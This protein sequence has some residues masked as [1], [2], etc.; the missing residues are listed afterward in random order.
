MFFFSFRRYKNAY[1]W[2]LSCLPHFYNSQIVWERTH[3]GRQPSAQSSTTKETRSVPSKSLFG[4]DTRT[5]SYFMQTAEMRVAQ[6]TRIL[7]SP[8]PVF[9]SFSFLSSFCCPLLCKHRP[10][11]KMF[12]VML[13]FASQQLEPLTGVL[14]GY[15]CQWLQKK[16][17][18]PSSQS[19]KL[20]HEVMEGKKLSWN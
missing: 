4:P 7:T 16:H 14:K 9:A 1:Y 6:C 18:S 8:S 10:D 3:Q 17:H 15:L 13:P 12:W 2:L 19:H 20:A 5:G 11:S